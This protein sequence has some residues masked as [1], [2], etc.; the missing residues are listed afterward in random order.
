MF[1]YTLKFLWWLA[2]G[3]QYLLYLDVVQV[4]GAH[5]GRVFIP[6][7]AVLQPQWALPS[8]S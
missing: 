1:V 6:A 5:A 3:S 8:S 2:S 7:C 4:Y